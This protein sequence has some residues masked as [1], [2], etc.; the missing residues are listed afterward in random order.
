VLMG[1]AYTESLQTLDGSRRNP[2]DPGQ[3]LYKD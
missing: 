2:Y 3:T 1:T